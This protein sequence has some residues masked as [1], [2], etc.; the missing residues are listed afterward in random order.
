MLTQLETIVL[1]AYNKTKNVK[2]ATEELGM[3]VHT[4]N[5]ILKSIKSKGHDVTVEEVKVDKPAKIVVDGK[6]ISN[7]ARMREQIALV[8]HKMD[9]AQ[10]EEKLMQWA[11][12]VLGHTKQLAKSYVRSNWD[13]VA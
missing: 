11:M 8:K 2:A 9:D 6:K 4:V 12:E 5:S 13:R 3:E 1:E 7:A 10:A